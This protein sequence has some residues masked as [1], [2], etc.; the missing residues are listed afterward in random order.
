[1]NLSELIVKNPGTC[2][3]RAR[4]AGH[5]VE[6]SHVAKAFRAGQSP[7]EMLQMWPSLTLAQIHA[8]IA[9]ALT[10]AAEIDAN[11]AAEEEAWRQIDSSAASATM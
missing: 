7:E 4:I 8:A 9:Y 1:M 2:G 6:V 5:R 3:G 10:N 11:L